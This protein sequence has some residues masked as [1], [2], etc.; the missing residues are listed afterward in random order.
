MQ[1]QKIPVTVL[2]R[3]NRIRPLSGCLVH[4]KKGIHARKKYLEIITYTNIGAGIAQ[5]V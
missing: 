3:I 5:S 1:S 2:F 4:Y